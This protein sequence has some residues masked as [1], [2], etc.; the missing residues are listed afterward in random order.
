MAIPAQ[1]GLPTPK[2]PARTAAFRPQAVVRLRM[3]QSSGI[4]PQEAG[5]ESELLIDLYLLSPR[6]FDGWLK[7]PQSP[8]FGT[9]KRPHRSSAGAF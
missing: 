2:W 6:T 8:A 5:T 9:P 7:G 3:R 1:L 4:G